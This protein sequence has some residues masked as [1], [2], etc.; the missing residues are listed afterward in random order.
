MGYCTGNPAPGFVNRP[1][2]FG[3]FQRRGGRGNGWGYGGGYGGGRGFGRGFGGGRGFGR[4]M[5]WGGLGYSYWP[6][7]DRGIQAEP[8][9]SDE[10]LKTLERQDL[11][12]R[13]RE[14]EATLEQMKARLEEL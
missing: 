1:G 9:P 4:G 10:E 6:V 13:T 11:E 8:T 3:G 5:R 12:A 7:A 2:L 14:L